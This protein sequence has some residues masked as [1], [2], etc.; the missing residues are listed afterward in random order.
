MGY[1]ETVSYVYHV[2]S[3]YAFCETLV[4]KIHKTISINLN[5]EGHQEFKN[6]ECA[7]FE[8]VIIA[9]FFH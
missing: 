1:L 7:A 2:I 9:L 6:E 5:E 3:S 8:R 4:F